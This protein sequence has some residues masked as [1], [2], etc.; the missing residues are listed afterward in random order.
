MWP[1]YPYNRIGF[2]PLLSGAIGSRRVVRMCVDPS[3]L[4]IPFNFNN[5]IASF[6]FQ[7]V[8]TAITRHYK[9]KSKLM[10]R[11]HTAT[12]V[13]IQLSLRPQKPIMHFA[14]FS[15]ISLSFFP[16]ARNSRRGTRRTKYV[17][18]IPLT[19][20]LCQKCCCLERLLGGGKM[21]LT[22]LAP[23][24]IPKCGDLSKNIWSAEPVHF[25]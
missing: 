20:Y 17:V 24:F 23:Q 6:A 8:K 18:R 19:Q 14:S 3:T 25:P 21:S 12:D 15:G 11:A 5:S 16:S 10:K 22:N 4:R 1:I 13:R 7:L 2:R 9:T